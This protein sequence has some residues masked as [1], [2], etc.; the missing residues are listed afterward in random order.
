NQ[1]HLF[2]V[3][4]FSRLNNKILEIYYCNDEKF[5]CFQN[6]ILQENIL[7]STNKD[8]QAIEFIDINTQ[9][10]LSKYDGSPTE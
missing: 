3:C 4:Q 2:A 5:N 9:K 10:I 7:L 8:L 1:I 6:Q